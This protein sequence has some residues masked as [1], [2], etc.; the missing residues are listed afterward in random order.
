MTFIRSRQEICGFTW[1]KAI[2][3]LFVILIHDRSIWQLSLS[4]ESTSYHITIQDA[5]YLNVLTLAVPL[6]LLMSLYLYVWRRFAASNRESR[7]YLLQRLAYLLL[8][9]IFWR[10]IYYLF[11]VGDLYIP[12][13][14]GMRNVY[15]ALLGGGDTLLYFLQALMWLMVLTEILMLTNAIMLIHCLLGLSLFIMC[16]GYVMPYP[17]NVESLRFFS[18]ISFLPY[19]P[20][21]ILICRTETRWL[22]L[23]PL[24]LLGVS[25]LVTEWV[26]IPSRIFLQNGYALAMPSYA[27]P[28]VVLLSA[29]ILIVSLKVRQSY[30]MVR[31]L[32]S[33]SLYVYCQHQLWIN[34]TS[35]I[36]DKWLQ[37]L[38]ILS[39]TYLSACLLKLIVGKLKVTWN[40]LHG[41]AA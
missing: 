33:L 31:W 11:D 32:S 12:A 26:L 22:A 15:H 8:I 17:L 13:R 19:A 9:F 25:A 24:I 36:A 29:A 20:L 6:F 27:R 21:A 7:M 37:L 39:G 38:A 30:V 34:G 3:P 2:L 4:T 40:G 1:L 23:I 16:L 5:I 28:S 14:G 35:Q 10:F 18:P 41:H